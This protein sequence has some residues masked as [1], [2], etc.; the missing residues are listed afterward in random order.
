MLTR[1]RRDPLSR[2]TAILA[3]RAAIPSRISTIPVR[4]PYDAIV[5]AVRCPLVDTARRTP[6][7]GHALP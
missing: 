5:R 1:E 7:D 3:W 4:K 6:E 2:A